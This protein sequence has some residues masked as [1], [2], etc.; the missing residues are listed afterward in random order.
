[1][2][3]MPFLNDTM[4]K[5]V[6][7]SE[8]SYL[9]RNSLWHPFPSGCELLNSCL[10]CLAIEYSG[11]KFCRIDAVATGAAE[12]FSSDVSIGIIGIYMIYITKPQG[13]NL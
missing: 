2:S 4:L 3:E 11:V 9:K 8:D 5:H 12:R 10:D 13:Y 6:R 1:M 7:S